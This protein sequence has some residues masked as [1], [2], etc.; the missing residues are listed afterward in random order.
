MIIIFVS[1]SPVVQL[2]DTADLRQAGGLEVTS[3]ISAV[4]NTYFLWLQEKARRRTSVRTARCTRWARPSTAPVTNT[5][6]SRWVTGLTASC[7]RAAWRTPQA[8]RCRETWRSADRATATRPW[9]ATTR[10]TGSWR[11]PAVTVTVRCS[12]LSIELLSLA[13]SAKKPSWTALNSFILTSQAK[14][15]CHTFP[16]CEDLTVYMYDLADSTDF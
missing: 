10:T 9:C 2:Q 7:P 16:S 14:P 11:L 1:I 3:L 5:T 6:P 15:M 4:I 8:W 12:S 13:D